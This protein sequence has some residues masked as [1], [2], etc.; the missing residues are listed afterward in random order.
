L[1]NNC[2]FDKS[3]YT[4]RLWDIK[5]YLIVFVVNLTCIVQRKILNFSE[6]HKP[7]HIHIYLFANGK[8]HACICIDW[9]LLERNI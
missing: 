7:G 6:A 4:E 2:D 9:Q 5:R 1:T 3:G 8:S